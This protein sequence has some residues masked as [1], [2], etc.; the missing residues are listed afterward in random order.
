ML[1]N[2]QLKLLRLR[3]N[4][5]QTDVAVV[6]KCS[7]QYV[8]NIENGVEQFYSEEKHKRY[9]DAMYMAQKLKQLGNLPKYEEGKNIKQNSKKK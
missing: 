9:I 2:E 7:K 8:S 5:V 6:Y 4:L 1:T 3:L